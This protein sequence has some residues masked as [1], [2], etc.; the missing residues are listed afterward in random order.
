MIIISVAPNKRSLGITNGLAQT[1]VSIARVLAPAM[2][3]SMFSYSVE[4][5]ILGGYGVYAVLVALSCF[6]ILLASGLP[7]EHSHLLT[8]DVLE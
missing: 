5:D 2:A 8:R 1:T 7:Q 3:T 6:A 4:R